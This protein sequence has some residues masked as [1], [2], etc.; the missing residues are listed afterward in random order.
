MRLPL[1]VGEQMHK[2][3]HIGLLKTHGVLAGEIMF[4][5]TLMLLDQTVK[6]H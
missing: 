6:D 5:D 3:V 4:M 1:L 2:L